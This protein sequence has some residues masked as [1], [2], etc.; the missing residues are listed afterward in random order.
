VVL[1]ILVGGLVG[2]AIGYGG[3]WIL[4]RVRL[5]ATGL[6]PVL[7]LAL[8]FLAY[9]AATLPR[10]SGFLAVYITGVILGNGSLPYRAGVLRVMDAVAWLC[11]IAMFLM[12]GLL[13]I[14]SHLLAVAGT[15]LVLALFLAFV[16]R[17]AVVA[18]CL[19]PFGYS[20]R[21]TGYIG[22]VGLRGAVPIVLALFPVLARAPGAD[23]LFNLVFFIVFVNALVPGA[24]VRWTTR[25]LGLET[26]EPPA[27]DAVLEVTSM[28]PL[29]GELRSFYIDRDLAVSGITLADL[30]FPDG[31]S[32]SMIV[33]GQELVPPR[34]Q[35]RL[36]PGD[37]VYVFS[38]TEDVA[39]IQLLFGRPESQ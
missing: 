27:P 19:L 2:V 9:G 7:M 11:Q 15:G 24:T 38:R 32:V 22:W 30:P 29:N 31:A 6:Y 3:R 5:P 10:G 33:R 28:R 21:E 17:P 39:L 25:R 18:L 20:M 4:T 26:A 8:A 23:W 35:T 37:H 16:A 34:G 14:P 12:L 13:V 1:Q 36:E